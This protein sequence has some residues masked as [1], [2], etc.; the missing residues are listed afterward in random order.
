MSCVISRITA[1][2]KKADLKGDCLFVHSGFLRFQ[3][4]GNYLDT[5]PKPCVVGLQKCTKWPPNGI[6]RNMDA[7]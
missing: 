2:K 5:D 4:L 3:S 1:S 6:L 7:K